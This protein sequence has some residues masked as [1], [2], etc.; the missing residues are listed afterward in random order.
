MVHVAPKQHQT[1]LFEVVFDV[2]HHPYHVGEAGVPD[3]TR[4]SSTRGIS[5][6]NLTGH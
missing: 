1:L 5:L 6:E 3:S 2:S 4:R